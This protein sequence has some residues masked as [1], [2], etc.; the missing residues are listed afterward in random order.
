MIR[1][2]QVRLVGADGEQIGVMDVRQAMEEAEKVGLD[3]VEIAPNAKPPVCRT[4][5]YGKYKYQMSKKAHESKK[6]QTVIHVK[7]VKFRVKTE[8]HDFQVKLRNIRKFLSG[9]DRVKVSLMF[10]GREVTHPEL[11]RNK[12]QRVSEEVKDLGTV[13]QYPK[14]EGRNMTML[15]S[16]LQQKQTLRERKDA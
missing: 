8:E 3:L 10:R 4:M 11:G 2:P 15:I 14:R 13:E 16:P 7:E 9:G 6:K 12:L 1:A 5:D